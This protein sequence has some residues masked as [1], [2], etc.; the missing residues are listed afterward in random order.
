MKNSL[1][2]RLTSRTAII[3]M[4]L[5]LMLLMVQGAWEVAR[6]FAH[7]DSLQHGMEEILEGLGTILVA[8][9]VAL[10]ERETLMKFLGLYPQAMTPLQADVDHHC[11]GYGLILLLVGLLVEV[12]VYVV[13]MPNLET[14]NFDPGLILA[15]TG[16]CVL[17]GLLMGRLSWLLLRASGQ[18]AHRA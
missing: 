16:L 10:E 15:A 14:V 13:R 6:S 1:L 3:G 4:N 17:G 5:I 12:L 11:H 7:F 9:G 18:A 8:L 2:L